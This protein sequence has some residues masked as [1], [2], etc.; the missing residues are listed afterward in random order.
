MPSTTQLT[1]S[2]T[3][4]MHK[5]AQQ[6]DGPPAR[7][8]L[9][10]FPTAKS[11]H[12]IQP[13][14]KHLPHPLCNNYLSSAPVNHPTLSCHSQS[15][16]PKQKRRRILQLNTNLE[17]PGPCTRPLRLSIYGWCELELQGKS[18]SL[19]ASDAVSTIFFYDLE[20][21]SI[22]KWRVITTKPTDNSDRESHQQNNTMS[23]LR[24][25]P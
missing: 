21:I 16:T 19:S 12:F 24:P 9:Y 4:S 20:V 11:V 18:C 22:G 25:W 3:Q 23:T 2:D 1:R 6:Y 7:H 5:K 13:L 17:C 14:T 15:S 10:I 8:V